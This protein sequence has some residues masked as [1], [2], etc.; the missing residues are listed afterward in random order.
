VVVT[1]W[2]WAP[3]P[4]V[5]DGVDEPYAEVVPYWKDQVVEPPSG[6]TVP[7]R[8][9]VVVPEPADPVETT[10]TETESASAELVVPEPPDPEPPVDDDSADDDPADDDPADDDPAEL[11]DEADAT[12]PRA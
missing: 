4:T 10:G 12:H 2:A 9:A 6:S 11:P 5:R 3:G 1:V 8:V 7:E